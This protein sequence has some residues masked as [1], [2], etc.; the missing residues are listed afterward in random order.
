MR[1]LPGFLRAYEGSVQV[2][3]RFCNRVCI[4]LRAPLYKGS[5]N[6]DTLNPAQDV[7]FISEAAMQVRIQCSLTT[8]QHS[9]TDMRTS[10]IRTGFKV[11]SWNNQSILYY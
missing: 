4:G 9:T 6:L 5:N 2:F 7:S 10:T 8:K 1:A 11:P 3:V